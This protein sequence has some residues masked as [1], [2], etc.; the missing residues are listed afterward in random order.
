[1]RSIKVINKPLGGSHAK[2]WSLRVENRAQVLVTNT[3]NSDYWRCWDL[4]DCG[5]RTAQ[6]NSSQHPTSKITRVK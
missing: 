3:Y 1:L 4:E 5:S 2:F 6:E